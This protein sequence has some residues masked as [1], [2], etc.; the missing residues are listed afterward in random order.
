MKIILITLV[1]MNLI[2]LLTMGYDKRK[3]QLGRWR[4]KESTLFLMAILG[5][6]LGVY[7][8][9]NLFRHK[10]KHL[11]FALGIPAIIGAQLVLLISA[12]KYGFVLQ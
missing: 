5:G 8:G 4:I 1:I 6:S 7:L 11:S 3:A 12:I 10:T 2:G 9:M